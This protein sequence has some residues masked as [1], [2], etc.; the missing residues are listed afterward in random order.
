[1]NTKNDF[2]P[3]ANPRQQYLKHKEEIDRAVA[4]VLDG[5]S[6]ILG[7]A[8]RV[9]EEAF[10]GYIGVK[11][12]VGVN[13]GTDALILALRACGVQTGD[14]VITV[15][16]TAVATVAAI[17]AAGGQA[18]L[19][20]IDPQR[21]CIEPNV[22]ESLITPKTK[23]ILP[24]HLYGQPADMERILTL[25]RAYGLKVIEDCAQAHGA[26]INGKKVGSFGDIAC[27]SFYP[28]K[29]L[30]AIG[31]GGA[32]VT[33]SD[34]LAEKVRGLREYGWKERYISHFAGVNSR[35]DEVQAAIL[36]V[37]LR[38]LDADN[39]CRMQH[40]SQYIQALAGSG[41]TLPVKIDGTSHAM[42]LFVIEHEKRSAMQTYLQEVGIGTAIHYPLAVHQ[43]PAYLE[44]L[45]GCHSLPQ[46]EKL[47]PRILSLPMY[48]EL[49]EQQVASVC[50]R[51]QEWDSL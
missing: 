47:V 25:A 43:Q 50:Q 44:R 26:A 32:V 41:L 9:F 38:Y 39:M 40:A 3:I 7:S 28:T 27:F 33:N 14:E 6:Y 29:N 13:S 51:L 34:E 17:E 48:P 20:D 23:V 5:G 49:T 30:G 31:D 35:L 15:S 46:T 12:C 37:K 2:I 45:Q 36:M 42:H 11:H 22:L 21:R 18:V 16:H 8:T 1:M 4:S 10:A 19:A 24:V